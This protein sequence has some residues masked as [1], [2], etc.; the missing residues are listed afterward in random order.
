MLDTHTIMLNPA[1]I[2][3]FKRHVL[4]FGDNVP[5]PKAIYERSRFNMEIPPLPDPVR[6]WERFKPQNGDRY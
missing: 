6:A 3:D 4:Y 1:N 5:F 2:A